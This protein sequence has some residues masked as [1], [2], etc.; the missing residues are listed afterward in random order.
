M[1]QS[2]RYVKKMMSG[3]HEDD[4]FWEYEMFYRQYG[5]AFNRRKNREFKE[6]RKWR[7]YQGREKH[8][9]PYFD[10]LPF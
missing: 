7:G 1:K 8:I 9:A 2:K 5:R 3:L 4:A 6:R 10:E